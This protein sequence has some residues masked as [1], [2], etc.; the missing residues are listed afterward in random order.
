MLQCTVV[1]LDH[2]YFYLTAKKSGLHYMYNIS[3]IVS[4]AEFFSTLRSVT[5]Q[6]DLKLVR[7]YQNSAPQLL[8]HQDNDYDILL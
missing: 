4:V 2:K 8:F 3:N 1:I 5:V 6:K 7:F